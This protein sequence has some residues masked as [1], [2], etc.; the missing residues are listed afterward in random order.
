MDYKKKEPDFKSKVSRA[1]LLLTGYTA[2]HDLP[3]SNAEHLISLLKKMFP[4]CDVAQNMLLK[5]TKISYVMQDCIAWEE[6]NEIAKICQENKFS[7]LIDESTDISVSQI[8]A[9]VVRFFDTKKVKVTDALLDIIEVENGSAEG[10][11][12]ALTDLLAKK[13]IPLSNIIGFGSDNCSTVV[14]NKGGFQAFLK[15][16]V[17]TVFILGCTCHSFSLCASYACAQLPSYLE[18]FLRDI[19]CYFSCSSKRLHQFQVIRS[20]PY[21]KAQN[22]KTISS[23]MAF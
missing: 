1:E 3:F 18:Q 9:V 11:Y 22:V 16:D 6:K 15:N 7:L 4:E 21:F 19:C 20:C 8:L 23:A 5:K 2:E 14:G 17:P 13:Q 12:K 10:L